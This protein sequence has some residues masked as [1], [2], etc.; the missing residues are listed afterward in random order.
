MKKDVK[1]AKISKKWKNFC[2]FVMQKIRD[3]ESLV[4]CK[5]GVAAGAITKNE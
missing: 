5:V 2:L 4:F 1:K 3:R